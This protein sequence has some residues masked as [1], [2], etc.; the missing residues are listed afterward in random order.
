MSLIYFLSSGAIGEA[1]DLLLFSE[2]VGEYS[3]MA[4]CKIKATLH[5]QRD[6]LTD[7]LRVRQI[8]LLSVDEWLPF[9]KWCERQNVLVHM[10]K[11]VIDGSK[12]WWPCEVDMQII[13]GVYN[14][15][16]VLLKI[17]NY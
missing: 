9:S 3:L 13:D 16:L 7:H 5:Y 12:T 8:K 11:K 10:R 6:Q 14:E 2:L 15:R 4:D 1:T 17:K